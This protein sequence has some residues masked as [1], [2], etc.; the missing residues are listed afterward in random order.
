MTTEHQDK[1]EI[2]ESS[3]R[4]RIVWA[5]RILWLGAL[6]FLVLKIFQPEPH[7]VFFEPLFS[8]T[9]AAQVSSG[10]GATTQTAASSP[11][12]G[13]AMHAGGHEMQALQEEALRRYEE[14][15]GL[16]DIKGDNVITFEDLMETKLYRLPPP[17]FTDKVGAL[18]GKRVRM[19]GFMSPYDSL[20]DLRNFMLVQLPTGCFFCAP[21]GPLQV[22]AVRVDTDRPLA[23]IDEP[24]I[25]EGTLRLWEEESS[26]P[27]HRMFLFV[28]ERARVSAIP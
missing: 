4:S 22:V 13:A 7:Q 14:M 21:P 23:F 25:V 6:V 2:E 5:T 3:G 1:P 24:I 8:D 26:N 27:L 20:T 28:I 12:S 10:D 17:V 9:W 11:L 19:V 18:D 16:P 15:G